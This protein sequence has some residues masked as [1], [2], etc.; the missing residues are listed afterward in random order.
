MR[1]S[2]K[3]YEAYVDSM[4]EDIRAAFQV[5]ERGAGELVPPGSWLHTCQ[6]DT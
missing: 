2:M 3:V 5:W 4:N 1:K 6:G